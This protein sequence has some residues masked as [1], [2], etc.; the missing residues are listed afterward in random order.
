MRRNTKWNGKAEH[1][2]T[3]NRKDPGMFHAFLLRCLDM[4][5]VQ[6]HP[7]ARMI[8]SYLASAVDGEAPSTRDVFGVTR[9]GREEF[10]L[11]GDF[12]TVDA[13]TQIDVV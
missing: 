6:L 10:G 3:R 8:F 5:S 12:T 9:E 2:R 4:D 7:I 1:G 13:Q 11:Q